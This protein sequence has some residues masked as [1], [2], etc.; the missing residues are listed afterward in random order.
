MLESLASSRQTGHTGF[1]TLNM[2][3]DKVNKMLETGTDLVANVWVLLKP[4]GI[5]LTPSE[6][7]CPGASWE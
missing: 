1:Y 7:S 5:A 6:R 4:Q 3:S 2:K